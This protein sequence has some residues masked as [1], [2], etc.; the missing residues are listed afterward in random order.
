MRSSTKTRRVPRQ[1]CRLRSE[2]LGEPENLGHVFR[3][4][5]PKLEPGDDGIRFI[6]AGSNSAAGYDVLRAVGGSVR[7][8]R[9]E[10]DA[11]DAV[12]TLLG[13]PEIDRQKAL[14]RLRSAL[15]SKGRRAKS[16]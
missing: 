6:R 7:T 3:V 13:L 11:E 1:I 9:S 16:S 12:E 2:A 15:P 10:P 14:E 4:R 8:V 5:L